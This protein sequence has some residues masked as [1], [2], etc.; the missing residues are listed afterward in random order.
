MPRL[1]V[2]FAPLVVLILFDAGCGSE[3][4][5]EKPLISLD[6]S[7]ATS[8]VMQRCDSNGDQQ[9]D[10]EEVAKYP[11]LSN[12]AA[13]YD[14]N[15]DGK[16]AA[17]E[18]SGRLLRLA[19]TSSGLGE[20]ESTVRFEGRPLAGAMVRFVPLLAEGDAPWA[21]NG[22]TDSQGRATISVPTELLP[23]EAADA[24]G[25]PPG[26]YTVEI[27]HPEQQLPAQYNTATE[28]GFEVDPA[29]RDA[30]RFDLKP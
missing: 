21:G 10:A 3:G 22:T 27:T 28:L 9:L 24:R 26:L 14:P 16:I 25:L 2:G 11:P 19:T 20:V 18:I 29:A 12:A 30:A 4:A 6:P 15:G 7:K 23:E 17:D 5:S 1:N 13:K 8:V